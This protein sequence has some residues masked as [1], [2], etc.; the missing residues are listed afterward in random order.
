[1]STEVFW[2]WAS[3]VCLRF[4]SGEVDQQTDEGSVKVERSEPKGNL[5]GFLVRLHAFPQNEGKMDPEGY[6][7]CV[8]RLA[9]VARD[10]RRATQPAH[11]MRLATMTCLIS[12]IPERT[13]ENSRKVAC[14]V[15]AMILASEVLP[16]PG[17][18]QKIMEVGSSCSIWTR[19]GLPG[20]MRCS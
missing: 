6:R 8:F 15:S 2:F 5:D 17:G 10:S 19:R 14:V 3:I 1:M 7:C 11:P 20:P 18:P 4:P 16:T 9:V 12:L 13:A